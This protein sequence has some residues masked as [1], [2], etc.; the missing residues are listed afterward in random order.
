MVLTPLPCNWNAKPAPGKGPRK[1]SFFNDLAGTEAA[2]ERGRGW[3]F[4]LVGN[5]FRARTGPVTDKNPV[6]AG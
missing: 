4:L 2:A 6:Q 1:I 3:T 5:C